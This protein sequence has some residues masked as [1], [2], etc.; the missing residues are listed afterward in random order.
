MHI[1]IAHTTYNIASILPSAAE[2]APAV[3]VLYNAL[4]GSIIN[5]NNSSRNT[6]NNYISTVNIIAY[7]PALQLLRQMLVYFFGTAQVSFNLFYKTHIH[8]WFQKQ[9]SMH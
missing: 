7:T 2:V 9:I 5:R 1:S 4:A 3:A 6:K 8:P